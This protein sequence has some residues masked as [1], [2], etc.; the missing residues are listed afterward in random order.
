MT[1][2]KTVVLVG[3]PRGRLD[4]PPARPARPESVFVPLDDG[5][6]INVL[7]VVEA[8]ESHMEGRTDPHTGEWIAP[9]CLVVYT[10]A[11]G[12]EPARVLCGRDA[13]RLR[14]AMDL[15]TYRLH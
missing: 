10:A 9:P 6:R 1:A 2:A 3:V 8:Y 11:S 7:G 4:R 12:G 13:A 15:R 14:A 5:G